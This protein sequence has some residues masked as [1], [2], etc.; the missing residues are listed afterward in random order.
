MSPFVPLT[1]PYALSSSGDLRIMRKT[2]WDKEGIEDLARSRGWQDHPFRPDKG[3]AVSGE[4][5]GSYGMMRSP[6]RTEVQF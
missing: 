2:Q 1:L 4:R 3:R 5:A 6:M